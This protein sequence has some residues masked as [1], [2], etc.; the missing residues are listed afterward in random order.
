MKKIDSEKLSA[1]ELL[2]ILLEGNRC[3]KN[4]T[5]RV[6]NHCF[7]EMNHKELDFKM[8]NPVLKSFKNIRPYSAARRARNKKLTQ[9]RVK[10]NLGAGS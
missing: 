7:D 3:F 1:D 10:D 9:T 2:E 8:G 6:K 4:N 5:P